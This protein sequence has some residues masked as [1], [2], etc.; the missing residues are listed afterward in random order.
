[1]VDGNDPSGIA[2]VNEWL[3]GVIVRHTVTGQ[4]H[5]ILGF[6]FKSALDEDEFTTSLELCYKNE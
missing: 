3:V 1:M 5:E 2:K 6:T 4:A